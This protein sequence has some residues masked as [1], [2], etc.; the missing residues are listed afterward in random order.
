MSDHTTED[1]SSFSMEAIQ[2]SLRGI[3]Q[4][5]LDTAIAEG[6]SPSYAEEMVALAFYACGKQ[7]MEVNGF[8]EP[9]RQ[10]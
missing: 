8:R 2:T 5:M 7:F 3:R 9:N 10:D 4:K 6:F 1:Y